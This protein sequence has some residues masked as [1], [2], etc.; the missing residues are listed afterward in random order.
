MFKI[1]IIME[2]KFLEALQKQRAETNIDL[3]VGNLDQIANKI[4]QERPRGNKKP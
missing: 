2:K 1:N 4:P 3:P